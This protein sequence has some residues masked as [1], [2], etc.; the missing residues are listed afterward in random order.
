[1]CLRAEDTDDN[2]CPAHLA[3]THQLLQGFHA[4]GA[5]PGI[6]HDDL[7]TGHR[8]D[9]GHRRMPD[10]LERTED[11]I[12]GDCIAERALRLSGTERQ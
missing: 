2:G 6:S 12:L 11:S 9:L 3:G 10:E 8:E 1:V 5:V 4:E 7:G